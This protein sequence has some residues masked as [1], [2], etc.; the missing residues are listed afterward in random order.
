MHRPFI[1]VDEAHN[2]G[3]KLA[4]D[5]LAGF[6][7][8][9][10]LELTATPA[11]DENPSNVL[12]SVSAYSLRAA[13][14]IKLPLELSTRPQWQEVVRDAIACLDTLQKSADLEE[15]RAGEYLR[16][17]MLIQAERQDQ[18]LE[19]FTAE[20]VKSTLMQDF[21]ISENQI[22]IATGELDEISGVDLMDRKCLIRFIITIDKLREGWNCPFAYVLCTFRPTT[23]ATAVEQILGRILRMPY[24][25][26]K[27]E[28]PLNLAYAFATSANFEATASSLKDGLVKSGFQRQEAED[29]V[30]PASTSVEMELQA[31]ADQEVTFE[32]PEGSFVFDQSV[33]SKIKDQFEITPE[34]RSV[35]IR[36]KIDDSAQKTILA[37]FTTPEGKAEAEKAIHALNQKN[38][39]REQTPSEKGEKFEIPVLAYRSEDLWEDFEKTHLLSADWD[40]LKANATL[41]EK[42]FPKS[43]FTSQKGQFDIDKRGEFKLKYGEALEAQMTLFEM[44]CDWTAERLIAWIERNIYDENIIPDEKAAFI[45]KAIH[46]LLKDRCFS[47]EDLV[48][49]KFRLRNALTSKLDVAKGMAL[50]EVYQTLI[51]QDD[52]FETKIVPDQPR[53]LADNYDCDVPYKGFIE[54]KK[55]FYPV[56]GN[57]KSQGEETNC[58][59]FIANSIPEVEFWVRNVERK[60]TSWSLQTSTDRFY[61]DF[62]AKLKNG[63]ILAVEHKGNDR[64]DLPEEMEKRILG[65]LWE[66]RSAGTCLFVMTRGERFKEMIMEK[67]KQST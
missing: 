64:Y 21:G 34:K 14:M 44:K 49:R 62:I 9:A 24:A 17:I 12:Y 18:Q 5:I 63:V 61:P 51:Q 6:H 1:I 30:R 52:I 48:Y 8:S 67:I 59:A 50:K 11:R 13:E 55:H 20:R 66:K 10:I 37:T 45:T 46:S 31:Y 26:R 7:P 39:T 60:K 38:G 65:A 3:S 42:E 41:D 23:S 57:L 28:P 58:A 47:L 4:F 40:I 36:G 19:T 35:T 27:E 54:L 43:E 56:I 15:K 29:L 53:F 22:A 2:Q 25:R 32:P 16:P 33:P